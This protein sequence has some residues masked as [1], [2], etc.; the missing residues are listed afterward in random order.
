MVLATGAA[1][2]ADLSEAEL[3]AQYP[4]VAAVTMLLLGVGLV[5]DA[6][7]LFRLSRHPQFSTTNAGE[8]LLRVGPMPWNLQDLLH[9]TGALILVFVAGNGLLALG[10]KFARV[11]ELSTMPWLLVM[12]ML[13]YF[14][15]LL[16]FGGFFR[17]RRVDWRQALGFRR[18]SPSGAMAFGGLF[19][20]A[21]LPPLLG[22]FAIYEKLCRL[23][24]IQNTPQPIVDLFATS[25]SMVVVGLVSAF[26]I[27]VAP[28]FEEFFFRG[29]AY[30][31]LK[32]RWGTWKAL[33]IVSVVFA[34]IHQHVPSIGPLFTL[35][36][37]LGLAY[38]LTGSLLTPITMHALFNATNVALL[39]YVRAHV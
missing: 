37:G 15:S 22:T 9:A 26:A 23:V 24:G 20:L 25:D 27:T 4:V 19:F 10:L 28:V 8:P 13:L 31:A 14:V 6:Y 21:V 3:V 34:L 33:V 7:L 16:G 1:I 11:D 36:V 18:E 2:P 39:L 35:A 32:Q 5:C 17:Q 29:F 12:N 30:P 38:E